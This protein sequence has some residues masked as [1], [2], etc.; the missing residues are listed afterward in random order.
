MTLPINE[1]L[2]SSRKQVEKTDRYY[3]LQVRAWTNMDPSDLTL[4]QLAESV[5]AGKGVLTAIEIVKV[6]DEVTAIDDPEVRETFENIR[7]AERVLQNAKALPTPLR[8]KLQ[9]A[10]ALAHDSH[11]SAAA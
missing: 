10:L 7:A 3:K 1:Q 8:E 9:S 4:S 2:A 5:E 11:T 6:A